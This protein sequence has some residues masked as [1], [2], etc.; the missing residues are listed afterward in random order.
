[1]LCFAFLILQKLNLL[2]G[3]KAKMAAGK[4]GV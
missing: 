1:L 3:K 4:K 2:T